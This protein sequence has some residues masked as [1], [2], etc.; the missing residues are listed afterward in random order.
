MLL[1]GKDDWAPAAP[2]EAPA[3]SAA[4]ARRSATAVVH[5][6]PC[7]HLD[8]ADVGKLAIVAE[9]R[10]GGGATVDHDPRADAEKQ[11]R[12]FPGAQPGT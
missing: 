6:D 5:P 3:R 12:A 2:C 8:G 11:V 10:G 7:H 9:A 1:G 4:A